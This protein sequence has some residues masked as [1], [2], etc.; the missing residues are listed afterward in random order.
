MSF[1]IIY[2]RTNVKGREKSGYMKKG[3]QT[4]GLETRDHVLKSPEIDKNK[5]KCFLREQEK[6]CGSVV[7]KDRPIEP[8]TTSKTKRNTPDQYENVISVSD[9]AKKQKKERKER[10]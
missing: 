8:K 10:K 4:P 3:V 2:V 5:Q 1:V 7:V 9:R 6:E